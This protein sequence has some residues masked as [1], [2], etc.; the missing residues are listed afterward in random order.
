MIMSMRRRNCIHAN[1]A[2]RTLARP[3]TGMIIDFPFRI[4]KREAQK[5]IIMVA[6]EMIR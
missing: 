5:V 2:T 3:M 1:S 4:I 6:M